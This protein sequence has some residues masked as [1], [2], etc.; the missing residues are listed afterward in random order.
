LRM[1]FGRVRKARS[2]LTVLCEPTVGISRG[3]KKK[4]FSLISLRIE[5]MLIFC[6][7]SDSAGIHLTFLI[8]GRMAPL[9]LSSSFLST[10]KK[11]AVIAPAAPVNDGRLA[12]GTK[13]LREAGFEVTPFGKL[14]ED[15]QPEHS[16]FF[17]DDA[18]AR[19]R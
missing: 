15:E 13:N 7:G 5:P 10:D 9:K 12:T 14:S 11:I 4:N 8:K 16:L 3:E 18:P 6:Q 2:L 19:V 17:S 1:K